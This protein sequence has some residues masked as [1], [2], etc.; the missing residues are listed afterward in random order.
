MIAKAQ[1]YIDASDE[2]VRAARRLLANG[3]HAPAAYYAFHAFE[4]AGNAFAVSHGGEVARNHKDNRGEFR[5]HYFNAGLEHQIEPVE[6][7]AYSVRNKSRYPREN[8]R[9]EW[10]A[11]SQQVDR[12]IAEE[13]L[14]RVR[15]VLPTIKQNL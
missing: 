13:V 9:G 3:L 15:G 10:Q 2:A 1:T 5:K 11:P 7:L 12:E 4:S 6:K 14:R 8:E